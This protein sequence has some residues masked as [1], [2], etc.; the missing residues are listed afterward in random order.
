MWKLTHVSRHLIIVQDIIVGTYNL[1]LFVGELPKMA[2]LLAN[3]KQ[4][5]KKKKKSVEI[6]NR[7][8]Q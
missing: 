1:R 7:Q 2:W 6:E 3:A 5:K 8:G 4:S